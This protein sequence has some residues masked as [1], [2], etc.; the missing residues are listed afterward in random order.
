MRRVERQIAHRQVVGSI[1]APPWHHRRS[2]TTTLHHHTHCS[3]S[4]DCH[5]A[6]DTVCYDFSSSVVHM[7]IKKDTFY[8]YRTLGINKKMSYDKY[9]L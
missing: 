5:M 7:V 6:A 1:M 9:G 4:G 3:L 8:F 2:S